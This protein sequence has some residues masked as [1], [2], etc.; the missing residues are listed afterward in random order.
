MHSITT[1]RL[2]HI[3]VQGLG[4]AEAGRKVKFFD[5]LPFTPQELFGKQVTD[6]K[7]RTLKAISRLIRS[8]QLPTFLIPVI[9]DEI[10][11]AG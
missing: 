7:E 4:G 1:A 5:L 9:K 10:D 11:A 6:C 2:A 3:V 8:G